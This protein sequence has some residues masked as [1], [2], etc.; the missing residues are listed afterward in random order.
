MIKIC[1][2]NT[3]CGDNGARVI[4]MSFGKS[5]SPDKKMIDD[6]VKYALDKDVLLVQAAGNS[7]R[8]IDAFDNYP[9]PRYLFTN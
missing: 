8:N 5:L 4:N 6:A 1:Y 7:K 2:R 9:N 3:L